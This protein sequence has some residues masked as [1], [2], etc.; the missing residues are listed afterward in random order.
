MKKECEKRKNFLNVEIQCK[1]DPNNVVCHQR[2]TKTVS[3]Y[4]R[5]QNDTSTHQYIAVLKLYVAFKSSNKA[6]GTRH[7]AYIV[8]SEL[9]ALN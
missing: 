6:S 4:S 2:N 1:C 5:I 7:N 9:T 3:D 8:N